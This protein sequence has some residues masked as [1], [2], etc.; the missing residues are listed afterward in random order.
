MDTATAQQQQP[1]VPV[2]DEMLLNPDPADWLMIHR[3]YDFSGYSPLDQINRDNV[4]Q[5][6]LAW[7]RAMDS[8]P[9]EIRPLV[10]DGVM[11]IAHPG[12]D[13][14]QALDAT[15]GDLI[16]D[17]KRQLPEDIREYSGAGNRT[18]NLAIYG[19]K[20]YH[21]TWDAFIVALHAE[22]GQVLWETILGSQITGYPVTYAV[23]GRQYLAVPVG[24]GTLAN[25]STYTPELEAPSGSNMIVTFV[26]PE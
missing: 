1:F 4:G 12:G 23:E 19:N 26:L 11:Y 10:Y 14:I 9:Q 25:L 13:H 20:I 18:R 6:K 8:G 16:W 5:L 3:T 22:T 17:Y 7:M 21:L 2:T 15:T 24:G